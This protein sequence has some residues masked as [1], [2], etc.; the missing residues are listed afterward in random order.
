MISLLEVTV[1]DVVS[2]THALLKTEF[3]CK[4]EKKS[5]H[6]AWFRGFVLESC[7]LAGHLSSFT[8]PTG[9][10]EPMGNVWSSSLLPSFSHWNCQPRAQGPLWQTE[11]V[12]SQLRTQGWST[13]RSLLVV[14]GGLWLSKPP[15]HQLQSN[16][17]WA[18][19]LQQTQ[20]SVTSCS[21][22]ETQTPMCQKVEIYLFLVPELLI[23]GA[24]VTFGNYISQ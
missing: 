5:L 2:L 11:S 21:C 9:A 20:R 7:P 1:A 22:T 16:L 18:H 4:H 8:G 17:V 10:Q 15:C 6:I 13:T 14:S 3:H 12:G 19:N 23:P 24:A